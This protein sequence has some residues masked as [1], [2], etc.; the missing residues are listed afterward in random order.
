MVIDQG[1]K[2]DRGGGSRRSGAPMLHLR[3]NLTGV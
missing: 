1:D 3:R 2:E